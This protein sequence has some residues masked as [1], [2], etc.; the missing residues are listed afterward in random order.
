[1][2]EPSARQLQVWFAYLETGSMQK[3]G[4]QLGIH[5]QTVKR[6]IGQLKDIFGVK[7]TAQLAVEIERNRAA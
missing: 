2:A 1:V 7:T 4:A 3:A 6:Y 5:E